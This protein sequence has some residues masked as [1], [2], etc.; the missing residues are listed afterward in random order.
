MDKKFIESPI[1]GM[2]LFILLIGSILAGFFVL[3][4]IFNKDVVIFAVLFA[5]VIIF[6]VAKNIGHFINPTHT[7]EE[8]K[9][10]H[11]TKQKLELKLGRKK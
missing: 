8:I 4:T 1:G 6:V 9:T 10:K 5:I 3:G 11:E 2:V 7:I